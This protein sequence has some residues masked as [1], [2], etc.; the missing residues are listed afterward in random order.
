MVHS[1]S[2]FEAGYEDSSLRGKACTICF[3]LH[4]SHSVECC[5]CA[6]IDRTQGVFLYS[7]KK[8]GSFLLEDLI[9]FLAS[10]GEYGEMPSV[11]HSRMLTRLVSCLS[12]IPCGNEGISLLP[13]LGPDLIAAIVKRESAS[14]DLRDDS[15]SAMRNLLSISRSHSTNNEQPKRGLFPGKAFWLRRSRLF[16]VADRLIARWF[17]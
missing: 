7:P 6:Y 11:S 14:A 2:G 15:K 3:R 17:T 4:E 12:V 9:G 8:A 10:R 16:V 5:P 1:L 13:Y